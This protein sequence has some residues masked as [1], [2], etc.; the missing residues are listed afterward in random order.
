MGD[1][2]EKVKAVIS[3]FNNK[4]IELG[5]RR[6]VDCVLDTQ[7]LAYYKKVIEL[8]EFK[9]SEAYQ[10]EGFLDKCF[11][12][13]NELI[14]IDLKV[15]T[16]STVL[17]RAEGI[18]KQFRGGRFQLNDVSLEIKNG[19]IWGVVGEN[20]NGKT[21][22]LR[23]LAKELSHDSGKLS[24]DLNENFHSDYDLRSKLIY[25]PQRTK[26]WYGSLFDN[27][28]YTASHYGLF[29][30]R[31]ELTVKLFII[32]FGLWQ[33]KDLNWNQLSSG[34]KMRF[35]LAR[36][37]LR[38]PKLLLLDEPLANLDILAQQTVLDDLKHLAQSISNPIGIILSSQ[39][40]FEVEKISDK[41]L[42]LKNGKPRILSDENDKI[43]Q[44]ETIFELDIVN[45]DKEKL[46]FILKDLPL[47][48][49]KFNG[50]IFLLTISKSN[51]INEVLALLVKHDIQIVYF[52]DISLSTRR[53]FN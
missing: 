44:Q 45:C 13:L 21:T 5:F 7:D 33:Y 41:V 4:D 18:S 23:I 22:L 35:E 47:S 11:S 19:D 51:C 31:N 20:G 3:N 17:I 24:F 37:F 43:E 46:Q 25:I 48:E 15:T 2:E 40:L 12:L 52:R 50:G 9:F 10:E 53:F 42:F 38:S 32:R 30:E 29:G 27:L 16:N 14:K 36:T 34:Y 1:F 28:H 39:Q 8:T 26:K 49:V 6:L